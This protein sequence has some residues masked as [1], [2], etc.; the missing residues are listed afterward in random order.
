MFRIEYFGFGAWHRC[1]TLTNTKKEAIQQAQAHSGGGW[2]PTR[3]I[4]LNNNQIIIVTR[5]I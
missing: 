3:I 2:L 5:G 4:D 1:G